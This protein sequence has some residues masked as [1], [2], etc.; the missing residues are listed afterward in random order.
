MPE[1]QTR[2]RSPDSTTPG[3][4]PF[5]VDDFVKR[6][7]RKLAIDRDNLDNDLAEV[8]QIFQ[9]VGE[10]IAF[11]ISRKDQA[12]DDVK[13][14]EAEVETT[15]RSDAERRGVKMTDKAVAAAVFGHA[16]VAH[17]KAKLRNRQEEL[18]RL[19]N[20]E[21]S[22]KQRGYA[23]RDMVSLHL[24]AYFGT[25][26]NVVRHEINTEGQERRTQDVRREQQRH[27][28]QRDGRGGNDRRD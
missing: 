22:F 24:A 2:A 23:I 14:I 5:K 7:T 19:Q 20:L 9:E 15:L 4:D 27:R 11:A 1:R 6:T 16:D 10:E 25:T 26:A 13:R 28:L 12:A 8:G 21:Q 18:A 3:V 17:A